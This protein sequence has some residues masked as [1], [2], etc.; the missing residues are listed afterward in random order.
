[1]CDEDSAFETSFVS[2]YFLWLK[3]IKKLHFEL[4]HCKNINSSENWKYF[5]ASL[6]KQQSFNDFRFFDYSNSLFLRGQINLPYKWI[7]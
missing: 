5:N 1:M 7:H 3:A 6:S 2:C 4:E